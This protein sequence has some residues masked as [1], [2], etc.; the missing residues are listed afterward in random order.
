M[1]VAGSPGIQLESTFTVKDTKPIWMYCRQPGAG[2]K[3]HCQAGMVFAVNPPEGKFDE[4]KK[5]AETS[6]SQTTTTSSSAGISA[7]GA[8]GE[9]DDS[10]D[11][12][13]LE[14]LVSYAPI[15]LGLLGGTVA[16]GVILLALTSLLFIR[17]RRA[18][19]TAAYKPIVLGSGREKSP[20]VGEESYE[21]TGGAGPTGRY[22][23]GGN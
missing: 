23:D 4:F 1:P 13:N 18:E 16:L 2:P 14:K 6:T 21:Y 19:R 11:S 20:P 5:K 10:D 8:L 15:A 22:Q 17:S 3:T 7:L 12:A 9:G